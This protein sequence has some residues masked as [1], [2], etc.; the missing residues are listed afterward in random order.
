MN[1]PQMQ[2]QNHIIFSV[3]LETHN[4][5]NKNDENKKI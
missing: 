2:Q 4:L 3:I 5:R 1:R